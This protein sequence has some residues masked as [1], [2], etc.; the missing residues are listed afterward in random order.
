[1]GPRTDEA[2]LPGRGAREVDHAALVVGG[3]VVDADDHAASRAQEGPPHARPELPARMRGGQVVLVEA[4]AAGRALAVIPGAV[5]GGDA[6]L[7][8]ADGRRLGGR[9]LVVMGAGGE[10]Q[11]RAG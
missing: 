10:G 11:D 7:D 6:D 2:D 5:P 1:A 9:E 3:A 4:L 8:Q